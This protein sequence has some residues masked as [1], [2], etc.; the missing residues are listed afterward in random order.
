MTL[1]I[2]TINRN[3]AEGLRKT[4][5]SVVSQTYTDF[6][7]IIID[8]ASTDE[9]VEV[10]KEYADKIDYWVSEPDTGIY[11]AMNKGILKA[12]GEY[13][14]FLNSGDWLVDEDVIERVINIPCDDDI[15][16]GNVYLIYDN[17][18][19]PRE[20]GIHST[21]VNDHKIRSIDLVFGSFP[22]QATLIKRKLFFQFGFYD[23]TLKIVSDW[24]FMLYTIVFKNVSVSCYRDIFISNFDMSGISMSSSELLSYEFNK[25]LGEFFPKRVLDDYND[26]V[27]YR[28]EIQKYWFTKKIYALLYHLVILYE[29]VI[30]RKRNSIRLK[31]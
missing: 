24:K 16:I 1:S 5:E 11:N 14:L 13:L 10:I 27:F 20:I 19:E 25:V 15:L 21:N 8:G 18:K 9:S 12:N 26:Y 29:R 31:R 3:N 23:E 2:I 17:K 22:H 4:I 30:V 7:Y 28:F 6:E